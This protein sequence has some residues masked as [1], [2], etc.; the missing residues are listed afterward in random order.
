MNP[1]V[2]DLQI[3]EAAAVLL[4]AR[5]ERGA[6]AAVPASVAAALS[7]INLPEDAI[8]RGPSSVFT[9]AE[10]NGNLTAL[11]VELTKGAVTKGFATKLLGLFGL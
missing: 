10:V 6:A 3:A 8:S 7:N 4:Q 9:D 1:H 11:Q 2:T 5:K